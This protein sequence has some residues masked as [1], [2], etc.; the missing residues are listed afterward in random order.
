MSS[1]FKACVAASLFILA[2][3]QSPAQ[4]GPS[5]A[6]LIAR[7]V[8]SNALRAHLEFLSSDLLEGRAPGTR[9]GEL[10][11]EYV[12]AQFRRL[13]L[14]PAGDSGTYFHRVPIIAL[15]PNPSLAVSIAGSPSRTLRYRDDYVLWSMRNEPSFLRSINVSRIRSAYFGSP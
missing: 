13:G 9:G 12:A 14:E 3:T 11:A 7:A 15:T 10:A 6:T 8:D 1:I 4:E 2:G 5:A